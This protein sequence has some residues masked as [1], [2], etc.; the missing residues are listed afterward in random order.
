MHGVARLTVAV[1]DWRVLRRS[2]DVFMAGQTEPNLKGL[3]FNDGTL[4]LMTFIAVAVSYRRMDNFP[5]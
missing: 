2:R 5:E 1:L 4:D 3:E